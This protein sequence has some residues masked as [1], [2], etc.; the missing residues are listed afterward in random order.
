MNDPLAQKER[1]LI[2]A[3]ERDDLR[4]AGRRALE[5]AAPPAADGA[6]AGESLELVREDR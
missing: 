6:D 3:Q 2:A 5:A 4:A 1:E